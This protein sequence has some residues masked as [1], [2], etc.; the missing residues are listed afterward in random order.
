MIKLSAIPK[1]E[2][3]IRSG[4][5]LP[6]YGKFEKPGVAVQCA[7]VDGVFYFFGEVEYSHDQESINFFRD[8]LDF[9]FY[10]RETKEA[11]RMH[12]KKIRHLASLGHKNIKIIQEKNISDEQSKMRIWQLSKE[13]KL[14]YINN[15]IIH[16]GMREFSALRD[17]FPASMKAVSCAINALD[18]TLYY[19][20]NRETF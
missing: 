17:Q 6:T 9:S 16:K 10:A 11:I 12:R 5:A 8:G 15:G 14:K 1:G 2:A 18:R 4:I 3:F 7:N 13:G 19:N 20:L